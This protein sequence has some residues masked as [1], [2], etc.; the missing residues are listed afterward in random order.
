M[1]F[2]GKTIVY[3]SNNYIRADNKVQYNPGIFSAPLKR[4]YNVTGPNITMGILQLDS[5]DAFNGM[6]GINTDGMILDTSLFTRITFQLNKL[7]ARVS[8]NGSVQTDWQDIAGYEA[9][10]E[11]GIYKKGHRDSLKTSY[12]LINANI[13][14]SDSV[15]VEIRQK[16]NNLLLT[17]LCIKRIAIAVQ[18]FLTSILHDSSAKTTPEMF[19]QQRVSEW[20]YLTNDNGFYD[21]WPGKDFPMG[22]GRYFPGSKLA[23]YFRKE[24]N[25][26]DS[27]LEYK[28]T[29]GMYTDTS[30][31]LSGHMILVPRM[32]SNGDYTLLVRYRDSPDIFKYTFYVPPT[33]FQ[34]YLYFIIYI[35]A[36]LILFFATVLIA[37][38]RVKRANERKQRL[39]LEL[40]SIR[41]QLNPHFVFNALSSIQSLVN[42]ND[43]DGANQ[44]LTEF[45]SLLRDSLQ[46]NNA[47]MAPLATEIKLLENYIKL[48][49]LR[50]SFNYEIKTGDNIELNAVEIPS[51]LLQPAVENAIKHGI[52]ALKDKGMLNVT[53]YTDN[54]NLV[55][56]VTDNGAGFNT[57]LQAE[58]RYGIKLT[59]ERIALLN[60]GLKG[61]KVDLNINSNQQGT[62]VV[63]TFN[64]WL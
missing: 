56:T 55:I 52:A 64:H 29:G 28:L 18:P 32:Q 50:F 33:W 59:K 47:D 61:Q 42:K 24:D 8:V 9:I 2:L 12:L 23:F 14:I 35:P 25:Y 54:D 31:I 62:T 39:A 58:G 38:Y 48:E 7:Q 46:N 57:S 49:Q 36:F 1:W 4:H 16:T 22:R 60:Q 3:C 34:K 41:S 51:L 44:Y 10:K 30:W 21:Y 19:I 63:F 5:N 20:P 37:R 45:S 27:S 11:P 53:F 17:S 15:T 43:I 6:V 13:N 26:P 40:K